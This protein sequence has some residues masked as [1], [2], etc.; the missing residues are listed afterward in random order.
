[1]IRPRR[2]T[3]LVAALVLAGLLLLTAP[4][5]TPAP[6]PFGDRSIETTVVLHRDG[7]YDVTVR[8]TVELKLAYDLAFGGGVHDGFRLSDTV[9]KSSMPPY[10]RSTY[11]LTAFTLPGGRPGPT[12]FEKTNHLFAARS[13]S[14]PYPVGTHTA[15]IRYRVT[16][17]AFPTERGWEVYVR[18]LDL[19]YERGERV[20]VDAG[21]LGATRLSLRCATFPPDTEACGTIDGST[22][23][24]VFDADRDQMLPPEYRIDVDGDNAAIP[25]PEIDET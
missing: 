7:S 18:L 16:G 10:L 8:Q 19:G 3:H 12:G 15:E 13:S 21:E 2:A 6:N 14:D 23:T 22:I 5:A 25:V 20:T 24:E 9:G 1:M 11:A 17:A 4:A